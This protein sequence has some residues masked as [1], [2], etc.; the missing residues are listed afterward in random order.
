MLTQLQIENAKALLSVL[1][2]SNWN[3]THDDHWFT[4][5]SGSEYSLFPESGRVDTCEK[6]IVHVM[7]KTGDGGSFICDRS[8]VIQ[9]L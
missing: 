5:Y 8:E 1:P 6:F 9:Q 7:L 3:R 2:E 4:S